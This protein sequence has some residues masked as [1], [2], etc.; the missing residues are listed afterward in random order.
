MSSDD[1]GEPKNGPEHLSGPIVDKFYTEN[2]K[3]LE[4]DTNGKRQ[5]ERHIKENT[6]QR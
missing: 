3:L 4:S 2:G 5:T 6:N 1:S